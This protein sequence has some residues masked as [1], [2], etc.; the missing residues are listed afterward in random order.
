MAPLTCA[1]SKENY[2]FT[3]IKMC[4]KYL[5]INKMFN[6]GIFVYTENVRQI[7]PPAIV[8]FDLK[9]DTLKFKH[10]FNDAVLRDATVFSSIVRVLL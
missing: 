1:V 10:F 4:V 3:I 9:R 7:A 2:N 5:G 8:V 6:R